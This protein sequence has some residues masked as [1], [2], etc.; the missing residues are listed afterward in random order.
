[1]LLLS[2][3]YLSCLLLTAYFRKHNGLPGGRPLCLRLVR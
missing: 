3:S 1:M 2:L